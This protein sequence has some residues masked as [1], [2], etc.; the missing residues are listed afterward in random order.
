[1][2]TAARTAHRL[3]AVPTSASVMELPRVS[4][5]QEAAGLLVGLAGVDPRPGAIADQL[6]V[7]AT[8]A[9]ADGVTFA[10]EVA[11]AL[12]RIAAHLA[13]GKDA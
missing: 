12:A 3:R 13:E 5:P 9:G 11:E 10:L 6:L 4:S 8:E 2:S 7:A 1:M